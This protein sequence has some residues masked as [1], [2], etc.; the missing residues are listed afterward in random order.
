MTASSV[1]H[2]ATATRGMTPDTA[3]AIGLDLGGTKLAT[4]LIGPDGRIRHRH[5]REHHARDY[6]A[7]LDAITGAVRECD[8]LGYAPVVGLAVAGPLDRDRER[9]LAALNLG[10]ADRPLR[11]DLRE[12]LGRP[13][14]L[15]NDANAAALAEHRVGAGAGARCLVLL[16]LGTGIGGGIVVDGQ[17]LRGAAG[18]AAELG[19]LPVGTDGAGCGCGATGC[20]ELYASGTALGRLAGAGRTSRDVVAAADRGDPTARRLLA[21]AGERLGAAV[22]MLAPAID[23]DVVMLGGG[24]AHAAAGHLLPALRDRLTV[25]WP[26]R[27][28]RAPARVCLAGCGVD[29]GAIGAA[30]CAMDEAAETMPAGVGAGF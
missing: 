10:F 16:T 2:R 6:P 24:L 1:V 20:L 18:A 28:R 17:V 21:E 9:V 19:H 4:V 26:F 5:H 15:E 7:V 27:A 13:V 22:L 3:L 12:R 29:A 23:P 30:L 11:A 25:G 8:T 14:V